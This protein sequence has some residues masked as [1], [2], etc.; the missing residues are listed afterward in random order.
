M[1]DTTSLWKNIREFNST[2]DS[3]GAESWRNTVVATSPML[4]LAQ[5]NGAFSEDILRIAFSTTEDGFLT[6][7]RRTQRINPSIVGM[8]SCCLVGVIWTGTLYV[9]NVGDS[10]AVIGSL[11]LK[12]GV[13]CV[14]GIL[15][16]ND[17]FLIFA[18]DGLWE[19][20][21]NQEAA[22]IGVARRLLKTALDIAASERD[23][24]Y[25]LLKQ[26]DKEVRRHFHDDSP[27][28]AIFKD[29]ICWRRGSPY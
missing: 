3:L 5:E 7:V 13:W 18:S 26:F 24:T 21:T 29:H 20:L 9:A 8:G 23:I 25:K 27:V 10:Q 28:V 16:P 1:W 17:K 2:Q 12:H 14:K 6:L 15:Q 19:F 22:E 11:V 4:R